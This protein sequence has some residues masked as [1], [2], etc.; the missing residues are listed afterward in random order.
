MG[1]P[2]NEAAAGGVSPDQAVSSDAPA[3]E[4]AEDAAAAQDGAGGQMA[5]AVSQV[6][7]AADAV[8]PGDVGGVPS[9]PV[10]VRS[11]SRPSG[12]RL[13]AAAE[14]RRVAEAEA[15][16]EAEGDEPQEPP[17]E[18]VEEAEQAVL[19]DL[20]KL[21][22]ERDDYLDQ[23]KRTKAD[24]ENYR[25]RIIRQQ[26]EHLERAAEG[27]AEKLLPVLDTF[28]AALAH[29]EGFEQV[30]AALV[31]ALEKEGLERIEPEGKPFDP[32]ESDAVAHEEGEGG[33]IVAEVLR[34]GYRWK[35]RVLRPAMVRVRG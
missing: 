22:A 9:R 16:G 15:A 8:E 12:G 34:P 3:V 13:W 25:K 35:G 14:A 31:T 20:A 29:G 24:F 23:L 21:A 28:D 10:R 5:E 11:S 30:Y 2:E 17:G 1:D 26:T 19:A 32:N 27:L 33:P 6:P 4:P 18:G 7:A